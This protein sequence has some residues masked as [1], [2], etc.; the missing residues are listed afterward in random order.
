MEERSA[1]TGKVAGSNPVGTTVHRLAISSGGFLFLSPPQG[2]PKGVWPGN[3]LPAAPDYLGSA[4]KT[5]RI[6][7]SLFGAMVLAVS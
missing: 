2:A 4:G 7:L 3:S 1:H 6:E 5:R